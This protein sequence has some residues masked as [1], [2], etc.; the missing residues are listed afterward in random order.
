MRHLALVLVMLCIS[1]PVD[2]GE[3]KSFVLH[4]RQ[5]PVEGAVVGGECLGRDQHGEERTVGCARRRAS[6]P[7]ALLDGEC[8]ITVREWNDD[9]LLILENWGHELGHCVEGTWHD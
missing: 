9:A 8:W 4:V 1:L 6:P 3:W 7:L 5:G 2:A